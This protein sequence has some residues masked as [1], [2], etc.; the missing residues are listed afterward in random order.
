V[1]VKAAGE[2]L[3]QKGAEVEDVRARI[4][5]LAAGL[6]GPHVDHAK[7]DS[8][9][10]G[11]SRDRP[12]LERADSAG[13]LRIYDRKRTTGRSSCKKFPGDASNGFGPMT[14][15]ERERLFV[16]LFEQSRAGI[17]RLCSSYLNSATE[18]DDLFQ[19]IMTNVWNNL[20]RFRGEAKLS[21]WVYRIAVN[22]ALTYR[23]RQRPSEELPEMT[24]DRV[25]TQRDLERQEQ[26][27]ALHRA[28]AQLGDQD[29]LIVSLLLEGL[30][31]KEIADVTGITVNYVGVKVSRIKQVLE[32]LMTGVSHGT[33]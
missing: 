30:T 24:D 16:L 6:L 22:T 26:L 18:V 1:P 2:Q 23:R 29:R 15:A 17:R 9:G 28:I 19:E 33:V 13:M 21:T 32:Q 4:E 25:S 20:A 12:K 7:A 31:Y 14:N 11:T 8:A 3:I 10:P 27:E 5:R